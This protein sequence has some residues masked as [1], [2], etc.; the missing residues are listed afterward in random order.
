MIIWEYPRQ[1]SKK[2]SKGTRSINNIVIVCPWWQYTRG[3]NFL[4]K[5]HIIVAPV[6]VDFHSIDGHKNW[7][8]LWGAI[9]WALVMGRFI[10]IRCHG[11]SAF[12]WP[13]QTITAQ[14][15]TQYRSCDHAPTTFLFFHILSECHHSLT[16]IRPFTYLHRHASTI[17]PFLPWIFHPYSHSDTVI[18]WWSLK[19]HTDT[20]LPP[21]RPDPRPKQNLYRPSNH[22]SVMGPETGL[23]HTDALVFVSGILC[24]WTISWCKY[25]ISSLPHHI[26]PSQSSSW[27]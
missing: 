9:S 5:Q 7:G 21:L 15:R 10:F 18:L 19:P 17:I 14:Q 4:N 16:T 1:H 20:H 26:S 13:N 12:K 8:P 27:R 22:P 25:V 2:I 23:F 6:V 24:I 3:R 11:S